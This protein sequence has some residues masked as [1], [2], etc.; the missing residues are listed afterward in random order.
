[1]NTCC[2]DV[3]ECLNNNSG[4]NQGCNNTVGSFNCYCN[5]GYSL[6]VNGFLCEGMYISIQ[7]I[8]SR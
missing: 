3:N 7:I 1:M 8:V 4:C 6:T 5:E 2:T